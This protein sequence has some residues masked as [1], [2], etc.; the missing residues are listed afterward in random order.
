MTLDE[1]K[2]MYKNGSDFEQ[3]TG[4]VHQN[5]MNWNKRGSIPIRA[6]IRLEKITKGALVARI[7]DDIFG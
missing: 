7:Q 6:Q 4:L 5:W 3:Q 1:L 2:K